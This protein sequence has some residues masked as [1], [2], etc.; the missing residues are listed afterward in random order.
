MISKIYG[1]FEEQ[2]QDVTFGQVQDSPN[3]ILNMNIQ[4]QGGSRFFDGK[5]TTVVVSVYMRD[6]KFRNLM[7]RYDELVDIMESTYDRMVDGI[8][9]VTTVNRGT[10]DLMRDEENRYYLYTSFEMLVEKTN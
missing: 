10:Q 6:E 1:Y 7:I 2:W 5:S 3:N 9:I 8:H 4:D